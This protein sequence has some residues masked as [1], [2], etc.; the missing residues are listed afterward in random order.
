MVPC[1]L[2]QW[3][4]VYAWAP[5]AAPRMPRWRSSGLHV[6]TRSKSAVT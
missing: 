4:L 2:L 1:R 5:G 6:S 3:L